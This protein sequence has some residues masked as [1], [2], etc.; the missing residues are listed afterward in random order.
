MNN[1][2]NS[3]NHPRFR[4]LLDDLQAL[5]R[6]GEHDAHCQGDSFSSNGWQWPFPD[7][8]LS[9]NT[10][11]GP[12][13][14]AVRS[15]YTTSVSPEAYLENP[16]QAQTHFS[17]PPWDTRSH[18]T[19]CRQE[20]EDRLS[21]DRRL[22]ASHASPDSLSSEIYISDM[23]LL[24]LGL[25]GDCT[26]VEESKS[27]EPE[28]ATSPNVDANILC[29]LEPFNRGIDLPLSSQNISVS[30]QDEHLASRF[31]SHRPFSMLSST[32]ASELQSRSL[33][34]DPRITAG[35]DLVVSM[36]DVS[37]PLSSVK[38]ILK[39]EDC[40][41][42]FS[43]DFRQGNMGRHKRHVHGE[44]D[45]FCHYPSCTR[46]FKR[47]DARKKHV[48]SRHPDDPSAHQT[49]DTERQD[50][51]PNFPCLAPGC[52]HIFKRNAELIQHARTHVLQSERPHRCTHCDKSFLYPKDLQRHKT[53]HSKINSEPIYCHVDS[54]N[55]G[56]T[57]QDSLL[58][59][60]KRAHPT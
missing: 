41:A 36:S 17:H 54:C 51:H 32:T 60:M 48:R 12:P 35:N 9:C 47:A 5:E 25:S 33:I 55:S 3:N 46:V 16:H 56:F 18:T 21:G 29:Y 59:H 10:P 28:M 1:A 8:G 24:E 38:D 30:S 39:C 23:S 31:D 34:T 57:R 58:R 19:A 49:R 15:G 43:G 53:T 50:P 37:E 26:S 22:R 52:S 40:E 42:T 11:T 45:Y 14:Q 4:D 7:A 20:T 2:H 13:Q 44:K 27:K 6:D